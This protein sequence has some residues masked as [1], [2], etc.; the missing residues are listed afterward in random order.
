MSTRSMED[1]ITALA[2]VPEE[3]DQEWVNATLAG[4]LAD[5]PPLQSRWRRRRRLAPMAV[6]G[7]LTVSTGTAVAA[8]GDPIGAVRDVL[9]AFSKE[10]NTTGNDIGTLGTP[11]LVAEFRRD[12]G[13]LF[14]FWIATSSS[15]E[16]CYA[17]SDA[18]WDGE[19][20][21]T[22]SQLEHGCAGEVSDP[23]D[24]NHVVPLE[25]PDQL[26]GFFKDDGEP[27]LYGVSPYRDA[28][29][30]RV[31]GSGVDR[32][33]PL[34]ADSLGYG[35]TLPG[36]SRAESLTLTFLDSAGHTLGS[37]TVVAPVG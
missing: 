20:T 29:V 21:P 27:I 28:V 33:L 37:K 22:A 4:I 5:N 11:R 17:Y 15:G 10:P 8:G 24:P 36:A 31:Q 1:R 18:N 30:V 23:S 32:T 14:A 7:V 9:L 26:G 6:A 25:R 19:G 3:L 34:R 12:N 13:E 16:V 2:P 35:S